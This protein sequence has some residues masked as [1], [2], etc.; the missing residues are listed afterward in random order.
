[1]MNLASRRTVSGVVM[2][3]GKVLVAAESERD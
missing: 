3:T 2:A 1:V